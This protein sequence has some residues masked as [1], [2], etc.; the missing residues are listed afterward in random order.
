MVLF[1]DVKLLVFATLLNIEKRASPC[2]APLMRL[3]DEHLTVKHELSD[4]IGETDMNTRI[5]VKMK[6]C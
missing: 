1:T 3:A 6:M 5:L 4:L 2:L